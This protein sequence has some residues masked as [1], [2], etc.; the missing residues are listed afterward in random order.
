M[1]DRRALA[2]PDT[3]G[4]AQEV[5]LSRADAGCETEDP[6]SQFRE[7][8][9]HQ[10]TRRRREGSRVPPRSEGLREPH[11]ERA[12]NDHGIPG[13]PGRQHVEVQGKI[14]GDR[15]GTEQYPLR[16][17][18]QERLARYVQKTYVGLVFR[19]GPRQLQ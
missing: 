16:L 12:E 9:R 5:R 7:A 4:A 1:A 19:P 14:R 8:L 2:V 3:R 11:V 13:L 18:T 15:G 17:D 10:A 6:G